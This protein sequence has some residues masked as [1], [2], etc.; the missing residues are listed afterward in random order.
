M[1]LYTGFLGIF[2]AAAT[3]VSGIAGA[4]S[5]DCNKA[6]T[7]S[8]KQICSS[9]QLQ[10]ED[11]QL[12]SAYVQALAKSDDKQALRSEQRNWINQR[13]MCSTVDCVSRSMELRTQS[14][15]DLG[16][17]NS[18]VVPKNSRVRVATAAKNDHQVST[19]DAPMAVN[20]PQLQAT[21]QSQ[22]EPGRTANLRRDAIEAR[23]LKAGSFVMAVL[24]LICIWLH[25]R[26]SMVIYSC[27]TDA[28]WTTMTPF[29]SVGAYFIAKS[30]LELA[31]E[32]SLIIAL[33]VAGLMSLQII[34]QTFR[35]NGFSLFFLLALYA[36]LVLFSIYFVSM[37]ALLLGGGRTASD[38]RRRRKWALG[39]S[40]LFAALTSWMC[41]NRQFS[42]IDD[43]IAGRT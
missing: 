7:Y 27:Y 5:F 20:A 16:G 38:R 9:S 15:L 4:T 25:S 37:A 24:L 14:L 8:E 34:I 29:F 26:G 3:V 41:R 36:K 39:G 6:S 31:A 19:P 1:R 2:F 35:S 17:P 21:P 42:H 11:E 40:V 32:T 28:L 13:D 12:N 33:L 10:L 43:Y 18:K 23:T 30:W 22:V